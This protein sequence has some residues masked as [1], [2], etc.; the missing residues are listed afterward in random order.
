MSID[1]KRRIEI[2]DTFRL[3]CLFAIEEGNVHYPVIYKR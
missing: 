1:K 3:A 2:C